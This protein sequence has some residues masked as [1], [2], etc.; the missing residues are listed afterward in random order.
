MEFFLFRHADYE[1]LYS[2]T[3]DISTAPLEKRVHTIHGSLLIAV[4]TFFVLVYIPTLLVMYQYLKK[5]AY[6][7]MIV[8]GLSD[9]FI[10]TFVV[11]PYGIMS[12]TGDVFCSHPSLSYI[13]GCASGGLW[14]LSTEMSCILALY[15]CLELWRPFVADA[16]FRGKK[17]L[18]WVGFSFIHLFVTILF[19]MPIIYSSLVGS[20]VLN[21]HA[22]YIDDAGV[23]S[24][25]QAL[26]ICSCAA[27]SDAHW[28]II[29]SGQ[30][31]SQMVCFVGMY[32]WICGYGIPGLIYI[33][34]NRTVRHSLLRIVDYNMKRSIVSISRKV[35]Q[36]R[37]QTP[38]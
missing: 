36:V 13:I 21:P 8:I 12:I 17:T 14:V 15:R 3:Y 24:L 34:M 18:A 19:G 10:L 27:I 2:C 38:L 9:V 1:K 5:T 28:T 7:L 32:I 37:S 26:V 4:S 6:Q 16:L 22:G 20:M 11:I 35:E 23:I 33:S 29:F 25:I 30:S 31:P